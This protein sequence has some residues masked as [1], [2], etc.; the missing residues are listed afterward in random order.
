MG[1]S[2]CPLLGILRLLGEAVVPVVLGRVPFTLGPRLTLGTVLR[3]TA[4]LRGAG[5]ALCGP[6]D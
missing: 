6:G 4:L 3:V 2:L 1:Q 5:E